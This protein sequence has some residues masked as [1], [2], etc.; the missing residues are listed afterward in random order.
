VIQD[1]LMNSWQQSC[2]K[3]DFQN[4]RHLY[5]RHYWSCLIYSRE[6]NYDPPFCFL[7]QENHLVEHPIQYLHKKIA[8]IV[9]YDKL[10]NQY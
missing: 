2:H 4:C 3:M 5:H 9:H 6:N 8:H 7:Q 1:H 10:D